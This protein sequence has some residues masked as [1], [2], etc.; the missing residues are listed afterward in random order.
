MGARILVVD[1]DPALRNAV[2]RALRLEGYEIEVAGDGAEALH[3]LGR[4]QQ[5][6]IVLD[7]T[8]P[9]VDGYTVARHLRSDGDRTPILM[10]TARDEVIDR[11][12]GLDAGADDYLPKPFALEEFLARIRALLRRSAP[13]GGEARQLCFDDLVMD[14]SA[15]TVHRGEHLID[16]TRTEFNLLEVLLR[17]QGQVLSRAVLFERVWGYDLELASNS[18]DVYIGYLRRKTEAEGRSRLLHT[19]RGVGFVLRC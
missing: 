11:V 7:V 8:M 14:L 1:D 17:N 3:I 2:S 13:E 18:L 15:R 16:L 6:A 19:V 9:R 12:S 10:L 4:S 5:E